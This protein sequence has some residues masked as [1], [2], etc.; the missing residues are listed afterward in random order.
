MKFLT[1]IVALF[2]IIN[3]AVLA[4]SPAI[5]DED[6][7]ATAEEPK[8]KG[9]L[10]REVNEED[11]PTMW[12]DG[13]DFDDDEDAWNDDEEDIQDRRSNRDLGSYG[14]GGYGRSSYGGGGGY[15]S[16]YHSGGGGYRNYGYGRGGKG[17][18]N[19]GRGGYGYSRVHRTYGRGGY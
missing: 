14:G 16:G 13:D 15:G 9:S 18:G 19:S 8:T 11:E 5:N 12:N 4:G 6:I 7:V 1:I 17:K 2:A 3:T 10:R